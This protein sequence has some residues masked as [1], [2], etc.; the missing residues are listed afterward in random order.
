MLGSTVYARPIFIN[1]G[2]YLFAL[3]QSPALCGAVDKAVD[4]F[5][6]KLWAGYP[7]GALLAPNNLLPKLINR[8]PITAPLSY[9]SALMSNL[10]V[11]NSR[12]SVDNFVIKL[13][14][15]SY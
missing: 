8:S 13:L 4:N 9:L 2:S 7:V 1:G 14:C 6:E 5:Q 11:D 10:D 15:V 3:G 12:Q